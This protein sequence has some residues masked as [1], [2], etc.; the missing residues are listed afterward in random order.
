MV[1]KVINI[2]EKSKVLLKITMEELYAGEITQTNDWYY[3][4]NYCKLTEDMIR[5]F[6]NQ[7]D[8]Y[9]I[10]SRQKLSESFIEEFKDKVKWVR[11][12]KYQKL[13][14]EFIIKYSDKIRFG[15]IMVNKL[16]SKDIKSN[17]F[18]NLDGEKNA[19]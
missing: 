2:V 16:I 12:G 6:Q 17:I 13:S 18:D 11:I 14:M 5:E 7:V 3:I 10:C 19:I 1:K 8:W 9:F 4:C 15:D